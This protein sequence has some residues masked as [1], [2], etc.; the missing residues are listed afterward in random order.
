MKQ[1]TLREVE[2]ATGGKLLAGSYDEKIAGICIDSRIAKEGQLFFAIAG[3]NT[4]G[5]K[6]LNA[7]G[8]KGCTCAVISDPKALQGADGLSAIL[9]EDTTKAMGDLAR[10]YMDQIP[11]KRVAVTGSVGKTSTRD[12][13][14]YI[15]SEKYKTGRNVGNFNSIWGVPMTIMDFD[16]DLEAV[17]LEMGMDHAGLIQSMAGIVH[18]DVGIITNVG[19]SHIENLGSREGILKAKLEV[20]TYFGE[21]NLLVV[22]TDCDLLSVENTKGNYRLETAGQ[23]GDVTG[24]VSDIRDYG[25]EGIE[26]NL[27]IDG[28]EYDVR[29]YIPGAHNAGNSALAILA[30]LDLGIDVETAIQGLQKMELTGKRLTLKENHGIKVID[31]TYNACPDSMKSALKT[32][33]ASHRK[34]G[35]GRSIAILGDMYELGPDSDKYHQEVGQFAATLDELDMLITVGKLGKNIYEGASKAGAALELAHFDTK[36]ELYEELPNIV[37]KGDMVLV[38]SSRGLK[39]ETIVEEI[40]K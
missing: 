22:N 10:Y 26:Y 33:V 37:G 8:E 36:E 27:T 25:E 30:G 29:L 15:C 34:G 9:V 21:D 12:M 4:D 2:K 35:S 17:V 16:D 24:L 28:K 32:L 18:P 39:S 1:F 3:E 23:S 20:T 38:K 19:V 14:Y 13:M 11:A 31:D 6:Y 7:L 40:L 5:H